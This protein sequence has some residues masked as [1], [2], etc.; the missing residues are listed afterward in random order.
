[1]STPIVHREASL[2][3]IRKALREAPLAALREMLPDRKILEACES[4][5]HEWR[6][7]LYGPIP[8][9]LHFLV[10]AVQRDES[11]AATWQEL[12]APLAADFPEIASARP[13]RSAL[14]QARS[15]LPRAAIDRLV[16]ESCRGTSDTTTTRWRGFALKALDSTTVSMPR[17]D[18]LSRHFGHHRTRH[19]EVRYPLAR[20]ASLLNVG[21]CTIVDYRFGPH[22]K[23]E[24]EMAKDLVAH[25]VEGD[26]ALVDRGLSGTP[27]LARIPA[28]GADF[29]GRKN[30]RLNP[31]KV[32]IVD[33]LGRDDF[34]VELPVSKSARRRDR[35]LPEK[36]RVR[37]FKATWRSPAGER[38]TEW[39]VTSLVDAERFKKHALACLYHERWRIETSYDEFKTL[40][41]SDVLRSKTVDNVYKEIAA[42]VLAYQ[43]VRRVMVDAAAKHGKKP[44]ELSFLNAARWV[45]RF[46]RHMAASPAWALPVYYERLLDAVAA[47]EVEV[48][49]GRLEP[50]AIARE[51]KHY[52]R[53]RMPR[54]EWRELR[55]AGA[56]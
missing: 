38:V 37:L 11:F 17:E 54:S 33:H 7:R 50:R 31:E 15:R 18:E 45:M 52:P 19:G 4:C 16:E 55:M 43:L 53:L 44:T 21:T 41:H 13:N 22:T 24:T 49:P 29:L 40:F 10:Q 39:F 14:S 30:G 6:E 36:I 5:G 34:I 20:F 8:T 46:S 26:L 47:S 9:V 42:H 12:W 3:E 56:N 2:E 1:M 51:W 35:S 48:R 28:R 27:T 32:K 23:P 25:L